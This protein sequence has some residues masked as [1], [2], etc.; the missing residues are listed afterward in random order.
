VKRDKDRVNVSKLKPH[1][2]TGDD[3]TGGYIISLDKFKPGVDKG[4]YSKYKSNATQDSA[5][6]FLYCYPKP[7]SISPQQM[8]YIKGYFDQFEDALAGAS[9]SSPIAGYRRF[10]D[11]TSFADNFIINELSRNV[12]GYR[13][14]TYFYKDKQSAPNNKLR[15]GPIWDYNLGFG[16]A[17]YNGGNDPYW[18]AYDQFAYTNYTP[19]W[20]RRLMS[21]TIFRNEL[22]CR[23]HYLRENVLSERSLYEYIDQM[24]AHLQEAQ[25]RNFTKY[26][27][28]GKVIYPNPSPAPATWEAEIAYLKWWLH[29]RLLWM[30]KM[31]TGECAVRD[32]DP[33]NSMLRVRSYPNPFSDR[34]MVGYEAS[35]G[36]HVRVE[37]IDLIGNNALVLY[38]GV[39]QEAGAYEEI[40][41]TSMLPGGH[42][43]MKM[44]MDGNVEYRKLL[45]IQ[46][47]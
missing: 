32:D 29:E 19:W 3:V 47:K 33:N 14:S 25:V 42:Y 44:T 22:R 10:I 26:P 5:N 46:T 45:K 12:D 15:A 31:L 27:I 36:M 6:F 34:F 7:D 9:Y 37:L 35:K 20:W 21:D 13:A 30:D 43:V 38:D 17:S 8:A 39:R 4:W 40:S 16:N 24:A 41:D 11:I 28:L 18:W 23:Y 2:N 1:E